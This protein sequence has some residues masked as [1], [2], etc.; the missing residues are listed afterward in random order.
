MYQIDVVI[1]VVMALRG[2]KRVVIGPAS[3]R[4][5]HTEVPGGMH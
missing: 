4:C 3:A 1:L 5:W 2:V